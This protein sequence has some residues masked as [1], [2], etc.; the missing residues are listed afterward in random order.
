[1]TYLVIPERSRRIESRE[2]KIMNVDEKRKKTKGKRK[3]ESID[4]VSVEVHAI[5][6][7]PLVPG[8]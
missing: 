4:R 5:E 2:K 3:A 7:L 6:T 1:M 8:H